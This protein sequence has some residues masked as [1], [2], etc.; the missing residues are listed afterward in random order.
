MTTTERGA[1]GQPSPSSTPPPNNTS[2]PGPVS[3]SGSSLSTGA[4]AGI[5]VGVGALVIALI[6]CLYVIYRLKS[7]KK[8]VPVATSNGGPTD[9]LGGIGPD[10][11]L[12]GQIVTGGRG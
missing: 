2:T 6:V 11:D 7:Q 1:T 4:I 8:T 9:Q 10:N 3:N 12:P 5:A